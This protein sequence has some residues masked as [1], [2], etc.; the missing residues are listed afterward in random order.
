MDLDI[1]LTEYLTISL[2]NAKKT[3]PVALICV[4]SMIFSCYAMYINHQ[5]GSGYVWPD[6]AFAGSCIFAMGY[7]GFLSIP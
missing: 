1:M 6:Y 4:L 5:Q 7:L 3:W 2:R